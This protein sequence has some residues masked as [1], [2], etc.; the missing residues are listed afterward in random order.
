MKKIKIS[1]VLGTRPEIIKVFPIILEAIKKKID[2]EIIHTGQHFDPIMSNQIWE[3]LKLPPITQQFALQKSHA[4]SELGQMQDKISNY[5]LGN[6]HSNRVVL[7]Q[8]DT[9][10]TLAGALVANKMGLKLVHV[11]AGCRSGLKKQP[12]ETNRILVDNMS[13]LNFAMDKTSLL[14]LKKEHLLRNAL[15]CPNTAYAASD[16]IAKSILPLHTLPGFRLMTIHRAENADNPK[17]LKNIYQLAVL[18][19][20]S[21]PV[22]WVLHPRT[23]QALTKLAQKDFNVFKKFSSMIIHTKGLFFLEPQSYL[24]FF[25]LLAGCHSVLSDSG[26]VVDESV[27]LSKHFICLRS[28]TERVEVLNQKRAILLSPELAPVFMY[29]KIIN[30]ELK[31]YPEL[32][33]NE[34]KKLINSP[35]QIIKKILANS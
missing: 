3:E 32:K 24:D 31:N 19:S 35:E 23:K 6:P 12:E 27:Y 18:L 10:S 16:Y 14:N 2:Y 20:R 8:G 28:E 5:Y 34:R 29:K 22:V 17:R 26:G 15:V 1:F 13:D 25:S 33:L 7:V 4:A 11:E 21:M 30:F 9:N